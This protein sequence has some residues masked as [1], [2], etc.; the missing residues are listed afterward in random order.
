MKG[1]TVTRNSINVVPNTSVLILKASCNFSENILCGNA[2]EYVRIKRD[3]PFIFVN[4]LRNKSAP[5]I[6]QVTGKLHVEKKA[7]E[8]SQQ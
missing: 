4:N 1:A 7:I 5:V 6:K 8:A 3:L 2:N